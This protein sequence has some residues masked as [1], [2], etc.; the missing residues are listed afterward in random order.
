MK[1]GELADKAGVSAETIRFW[2]REGILIAPARN[3]SNYRVYTNEHWADVAFVLFCRGIDVPLHEIKVL[4]KLRRSPQ[5]SC[6]PISEV[7]EMRL[8]DVERRIAQ[9]EVL[10]LELNRLK[11]KCDGQHTV[12]ECGILKDIGMV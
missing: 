8:H 5:H 2:E 3:A 12:K 9:L 11:G 6:E 4:L 7:V 1:I 10:K